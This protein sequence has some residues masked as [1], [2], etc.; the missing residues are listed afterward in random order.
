MAARRK[1]TILDWLICLG[2]PLGT[3]A[4]SEAIGL[5]PLWK[6]AV[7]YTVILFAVVLTALRPPW[8]QREFWQTLVGVFA[9]H[10]LVVL[11]VVLV[12]QEFP[13]RRRLGVPKL[14]LFSVLPLEAL[15]VAGILWK[16]IAALK[17]S[18]SQE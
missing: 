1:S 6:D 9:A 11:W 8:R 13:D 5:A 12:L 3:V 14:T 2:F 18:K 16:R 15:F 4:A 17:I 7:V 10:S